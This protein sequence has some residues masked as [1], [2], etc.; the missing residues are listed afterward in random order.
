MAN[1]FQRGRARARRS[2]LTKK[3]SAFLACAALAANLFVAP[4]FA[5]SNKSDVV[6]ALRN[7]SAQE[8]YKINGA[9]KM[10]MKY[11]VPGLGLSKGEDTSLDFE[12]AFRKPLD[13]YLKMKYGKE[14]L[15][16][17]QNSEGYYVK[18]GDK[19]VKSPGKTGADITGS[20]FV[21]S[22]LDFSTEQILDMMAMF[23]IS[24]TYEKDG[25]KY[26]DLSLK[27]ND[28][29]RKLLEDAFSAGL[30]AGLDPSDKTLSNSAA[31]GSKVDFSLK[32]IL[33][34]DKKTLD[35]VN[36]VISVKNDG[37]KTDKGA[38]FGFETAFDVNIKYTAADARDAG[39]PSV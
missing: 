3:L 24:D 31:A 7:I 38:D 29:T 35:R 4:V 34:A 17:Y 20:D 10:T 18:T 21:F 28:E 19:W 15:E 11:S 22:G 8:A 37:V 27:Q 26:I 6:A 30:S 25:V 32:Y 39:F 16:T 9:M 36:Y 1:E 14:T 13:V 5:A 12:G 2:C 33:N 23:D